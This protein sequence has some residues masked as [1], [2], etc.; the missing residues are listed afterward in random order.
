MQNILTS[1]LVKSQL[2]NF[3]NGDEYSQFNLFIQKYFEWLE[4]SSGRVHYEI[5]AL[6]DSIDIDSANLAYLDRLKTDLAPYFPST[7]ISNKTLFLKVV[8]QFYK[9]NGTQ[10][11]IKF[12]FRILYGE[13][14]EIYYPKE[15]I[16]KTS[17]GKWILPLALRVKTEGANVT[18]IF[19]IEKTLLTGQTS[20]STAI[21]EKVI[22]SIDRQ[23]GVEYTELYISN[24]DR[25][26]ETGEIVSA[27]YIDVNTGLPVTA[28]GV[29]IAS[30]SEIKINPQARGLGYNGFDP[31]VSPSYP[32]DPVSIVGGLNPDS[33][34]PKGAIAFVGTTTT[35]GLT[36][37]VVDNPGFGFR[38]NT[39]ASIIDFSGGFDGTT[40]GTE[41]RASISLLDT[42]VANTR[43]I[44][45]GIDSISE[46]NVA[47]ANIA[48]FANIIGTVVNA[49]TADPA[50]K[51]IANTTAYQTITVYP[52]SFATLDGSGG[53]YKQ[54]PKV[55]TYSLYNE[56]IRDD[57]LI[58]SPVSIVKG[59]YIIQKEGANF[60]ANLEPG[61]YVRLIDTQNKMDDIKIVQAVTAN[62]IYFNDPW[63]NDLVDINI[64][65]VDRND[66]YKIGSIGRIRID[67]PGTNYSNGNTLIFTGGSGYGANAYVSVGAS[68]QIVS[69]TI[70]AH[71]SNAYVIGGEGY[72]N[73]ALPTITINSAT[74]TNAV[75]TVLE[76][77][78]SGEKYGLEKG[79]I[80]AVS[81][82]RVTSYGYDYVSAPLISLRTADL[83]T[84]N[85]YPQGDVFI[86]NTLVY[87][88]TSNTNYTWKATVDSY[89]ATTGKLRVFN[90]SGSLSNDVLVKYDSELSI[91]AISANV[92]SNIFYGN[93]L[94]KANARFE[95]GLIRYPGIYLNTDGQLSAD[96]RLQD[97]ERYHNFS[98]V[99]KTKTDYAKFK[100]PLKDLAHPIGV[101]SF[102][103]KIDNN[104]E[105][106]SVGNT[107]QHIIV[108][109]LPDTYNIAL[110]S[111]TIVTT[112]TSANVRLSV[113]VGDVIVLSSAYKRLQNT[114]NVVS[115]SNIMF[116]HAN[117]V[118]FIVDL[119]EGETIYLSTGNTVTIKQIT[120]SNYAILNT[121]INVTSTS[122]TV[123]LIYTEI[124]TVNSLNANTMITTTKFKSNSSNLSAAVRK[125]T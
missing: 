103:V 51:K 31:N 59:N 75:L 53:G 24:I 125:V 93:G 44:K 61:N 123:N 50:S 89:N 27:T 11:S 39:N 32:G 17:D 40:F 2:P 71:S 58:T 81:T 106:I 23:L 76:V 64:Y 47:H 3:I 96:K 7:I 108:K 99:I 122:A 13:N 36:D 4:Q 28:E 45:L 9:S 16:L 8:N 120:N 121:T 115:G 105:N 97:G 41:A 42:A 95:N 83:T 65:R 113:N 86:S 68:G 104:S 109:D 38:T 10:D 54:D 34:D 82:I 35:G 46:L 118:D 6:K 29:L 107:N 119:Q 25:L 117:N 20:K 94:A 78:G 112:N 69:V 63:P 57:V 85:I 15:D 88:G 116:G 70:N 55:K 43:T 1:T 12:L 14:I 110:G 84:A 56:L 60:T 21:V 101:K 22:R 67:N 30:L 100:K 48:S 72:R 74:G 114:V 92:T 62:V 90:Y 52:I 19:N 5:E 49:N 73:D 91:N 87:Q 79:S 77:T 18:N 111:N 80:G 98:Y 33:A 66:L 102:V 26:F 124:A 37:I